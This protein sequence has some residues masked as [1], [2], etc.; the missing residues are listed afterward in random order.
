MPATHPT[1]ALLA[2][3]RRGDADAVRALVSKYHARLVERVRLLMGGA[4]RRQ[5]DSIDYVQRLC[6]TMLH[7][8]E[9]VGG[10]DEESF[11]RWVTAVARNDLRDQWRH[12]G[13]APLESFPSSLHA[14]LAAASG[15]ALGE[16]EADEQLHALLEG[17][18][19]LDPEQREVLRLRDFEGLGHA[20]VAT[21]LGCSPDAARMRHARALI[22][23]GQE[24][25]RRGLSR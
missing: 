23:L 18:E 17:F 5:A 10:V 16:L 3:A 22:A 6:V 8:P 13:D 20:D 12:S 25:G 4:S 24:L 11:L 21:A 14:A 2:L 15:N 7:A 1:S 19:A 9:Q